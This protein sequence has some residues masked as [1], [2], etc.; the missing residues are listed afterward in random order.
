MVPHARPSLR[1]PQRVLVLV[2]RADP[3]DGTAARLL[4]RMGA[5]RTRP[6]GAIAA[7]GDAGVARAVRCVDED[8]ELGA[9]MVKMPTQEQTYTA[10]IAASNAR[11]SAYLRS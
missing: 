10:P 11:L 7:R 3:F 9:T 5:A 8:E 6:A 2:D 4:V 1:L